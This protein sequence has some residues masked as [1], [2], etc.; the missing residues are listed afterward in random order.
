MQKQ[1]GDHQGMVDFTRNLNNELVA[2]RKIC[3]IMFYF[4]QVNIDG[5]TFPCSTPGL[6][7]GFSM[8]CAKEKSLLEIWN[9]RPRNELICKNLREGRMS[10]EECRECS[11]CICIADPA[12]DLDD[13]IDEA[14]K[15]FKK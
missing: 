13:H 3:S 1:M 11:S 12:E 4:L 15:K 2:P 10:I 5:Q 8:G 7:N 6:P 9:D 14:L